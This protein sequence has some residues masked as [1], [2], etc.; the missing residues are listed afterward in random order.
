MLTKFIDHSTLNGWT[1][2]AFPLKSRLKQQC[3]I[4]PFLFNIVVK[5]LSRSIMQKEEI[6][7]IQT[8]KEEVKWSLFIKIYLKDSK[9]PP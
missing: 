8:G 1:L 2:K 5:F 9:T 4:S 6:K 3:P 7:R